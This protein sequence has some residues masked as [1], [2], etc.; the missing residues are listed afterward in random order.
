MKLK[1][2][3]INGKYKPR[4]QVFA[5]RGQLEDAIVANEPVTVAVPPEGV[6]GIAGCSEDGIHLDPHRAFITLCRKARECLGMHIQT[7]AGRQNLPSS[8]Q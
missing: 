2:F 4:K 5:I 7:P 8:N 6:T 3:L 1:S